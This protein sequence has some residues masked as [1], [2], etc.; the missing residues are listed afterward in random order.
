MKENNPIA[1][2][3]TLMVM[4]INVFLF[5]IGGC[6]VFAGILFVIYIIGAIFMLLFGDP[7]KDT[8]NNRGKSPATSASASQAVRSTM[9]GTAIPTRTICLRTDAAIASGEQSNSNAWQ[10]AVAP[11]ASPLQG[12]LFSDR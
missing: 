5:I 8:S 10:T 4:M 12:S 9:G 6:Y 3:S 1:F 11:S 7:R 2:A